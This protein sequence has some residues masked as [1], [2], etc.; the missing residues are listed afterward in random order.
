[1]TRSRAQTK[2]KLVCAQKREREKEL[3]TIADPLRDE[4]EQE[5]K[6]EERHTIEEREKSGQRR[7]RATTSAGDPPSL[8]LDDLLAGAVHV[9]YARQVL[10]EA[11]HVV[12]VLDRLYTVSTW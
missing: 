2:R 1:M 6:R 3:G 4:R 11:L 9:E 12:H 8:E 5:R 7:E 10:G